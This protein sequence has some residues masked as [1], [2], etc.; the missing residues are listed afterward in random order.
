VVDK[1]ANGLQARGH[2][3]SLL[4]AGPVAK[5]PYPVVVNGGT[6]SQYLLAPLRYSRR[7][8]DVDLVVDVANGIP[9]FS[10]LWRHGP[11]LCLMH[12][13]HAEQWAQ[14][15]PA[16]VAAAAAM[17]E[18]RGVPLVYRNT[19]FVAVSPSTAQELIGTG[20]DEKRVHVVCNGVSVE[21]PAAPVE[22]SAEPLFLALG[23]L[24]PN[25]QLDRLLDLWARVS[26]KVGGKLL[27]VGDGPERARI[28]ERVRRDPALR[29]VVIE[30]RVSEARKAELLS[31]AW[32]IVHTAEREGWGLVLLEAGLFG[33]PALAFRV[34]GVVDAVVD[35]V[36][37]VL[38]DDDTQFVD[39]WVA[40]AGDRERRERL[41]AAATARAI[42][43]SWDR[44]VDEFLKAA[45]AA[46]RDHRDT[47]R[48]VTSGR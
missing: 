21:P 45:D 16:P 18:G 11:R 46:I 29:D 40:L 34:P 25:K 3:V 2:E 33:T 24:A 10:P 39:E 22:R 26:P 4:C 27:I 28:A 35:G 8:R 15:F 9:F 43:F 14:Y 1:L 17:V 31:S 42:E 19:R 41:G 13:V 47:K 6:Y 48:S 7:F 30:G 32:L 20:V 12:H 36:T 23:R 38:A 37:G 5:R 44:S